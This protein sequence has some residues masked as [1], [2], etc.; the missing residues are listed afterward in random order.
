MAYQEKKV[1]L[2]KSVFHRTIRRISSEVVEKYKNLENLAIIGIQTRGANLATY[3]S[4]E[5]KQLEQYTIPVGSLNISLYRDDIDNIKSQPA[6]KASNFPF[7]IDNKDIL[8]VDDVLYTGRTIRAAIDCLIDF[9]RPKT[10]RLAVIIDRGH[11][12]LPIQPD[13]VGKKFVT[14]KDEIIAVNL[15]EIDNQENILLLEKKQERT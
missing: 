10:I 2:S 11:R 7:S 6:L 3:I 4:N 12:E 14:T 1:I 13:F 5:I 8:L 9:G 15:K